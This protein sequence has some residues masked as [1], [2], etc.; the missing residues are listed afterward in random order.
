MSISCEPDYRRYDH[1]LIHFQRR[2]K[3]AMFEL[4][5]FLPIK[6]LHL[7]LK[8]WIWKSN[9]KNKFVIILNFKNIFLLLLRGH[10]LLNFFFYLHGYFLFDGIYTLQIYINFYYYQN[11]SS[12]N[13]FDFVYIQNTLYKI[14]NSPLVYNK[15]IKLTLLV[16]MLL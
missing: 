6:F 7:L 1:A 15:Y 13:K 9:S 10:E 8:Y 3:I 14:F 4:E 16:C 5:Y 12:F 11:F 2:K